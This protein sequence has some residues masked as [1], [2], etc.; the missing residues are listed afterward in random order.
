MEAGPDSHLTLNITWLHV[1]TLH[2]L[3]LFFCATETRS[4]QCSASLGQPGEEKEAEPRKPTF[5]SFLLFWPPKSTF[6]ASPLSVRPLPVLSTAMWQLRHTAAGLRLWLLVLCWLFQFEEGRVAAGWR[7]VNCTPIGGDQGHSGVLWVGFGIREGVR[8][9]VAKVTIKQRVIQQLG[10]SPL[11]FQLRQRLGTLFRPGL[12]LG[13]RAASVRR[14]H[15]AVGGRRCRRGR[16]RGDEAILCAGAIF[17]DGLQPGLLWL[18]DWRDRFDLQDNNEWFWMACVLKKKTFYKQYGIICAA[19]NR[20]DSCWN[21][22]D[23]KSSCISCKA[24]DE[25]ESYP[26][27]LI[28]T[29]TIWLFSWSVSFSFSGSSPLPPLQTMASVSYSLRHKLCLSD[30]LARRTTFLWTQQFPVMRGRKK[31][32]YRKHQSSGWIFSNGVV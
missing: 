3:C 28:L 11:F 24:I 16:L 30:R 1:S 5:I 14:W 15:G 23:K 7:V 27:D 29:W 10:C 12:L 32:C 17:E 26:N 9:A 22:V 20:P 4:I 8:R 18:L 31:T 25:T 2:L 19:P 6:H 13:G 21:S